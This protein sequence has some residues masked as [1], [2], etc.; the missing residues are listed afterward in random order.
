MSSLCQQETGEWSN[1][2]SFML[3]LLQTQLGKDVFKE[4]TA[5]TNL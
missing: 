5:L 1:T 3:R 2:L 4:A